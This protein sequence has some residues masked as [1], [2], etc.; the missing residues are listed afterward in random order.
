MA[1]EILTSIEEAES[2]D[3][4]ADLVGDDDDEGEPVSP[5]PVEDEDA[6]GRRQLRIAIGTSWRGLQSEARA[7]LPA[8]HDVS[9]YDD[10]ALRQFA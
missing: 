10:V 4:T 7:S 1:S 9:R 5:M 8:G 2:P 3:D 6:R